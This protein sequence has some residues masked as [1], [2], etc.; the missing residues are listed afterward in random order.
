MLGLPA[1]GGCG[2]PGAH[3]YQSHTSA[4]DQHPWA[5][6]EADT[7]QGPKVRVQPDASL[8]FQDLRPS[9]P[10]PHGL[11]LSPAEGSK[12]WGETAMTSAALHALGRRTA[13]LTKSYGDHPATSVTRTRGHLGPN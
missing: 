5:G 1:S 6:R 4:P 11:L 8:G 13:A 10:S 12:P 9:T 7:G 3:P 2:D